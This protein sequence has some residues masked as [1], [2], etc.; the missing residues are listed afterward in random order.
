VADYVAR[1][2]GI[3]PQQA[4]VL[5]QAMHSGVS[6]DEAVVLAGIDPTKIKDSDLLTRLARIVGSALGHLAK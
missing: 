2:L 5:L 6:V 3:T 4:D 1:G